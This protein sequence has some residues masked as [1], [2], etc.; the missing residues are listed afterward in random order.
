MSAP[1]N[2]LQSRENRLLRI[3]QSTK[4]KTRATKKQKKSLHPYDKWVNTRAE[5]EKAAVVRKVL[6]RAI[7]SFMKAV[8]PETSLAQILPLKKIES[9]A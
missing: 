6:I 2:H 7:A 1:H 4:H 3:A 9:S 5:I 8:L